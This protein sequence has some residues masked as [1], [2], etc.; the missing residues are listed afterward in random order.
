M[1]Y[2]IHCGSNY[3]HDDKLHQK[4]ESLKKIKEKTRC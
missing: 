2:I 4:I 3:T 1:T